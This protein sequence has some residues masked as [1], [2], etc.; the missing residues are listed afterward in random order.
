M[1]LN[2][3]G[4]E[5]TEEL[6][7][8]RNSSRDLTFNGYNLHVDMESCPAFASPRMGY[9]KNSGCLFACFIVT[10]EI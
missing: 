6:L 3:E 7:K 1:N 4:T 10:A 8:D 2:T 9:A 5:F